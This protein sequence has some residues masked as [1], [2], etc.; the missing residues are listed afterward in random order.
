MNTDSS[1]RGL[2]LPGII[3]QLRPLGLQAAS[4]HPG[5]LTAQKQMSFSA[6][7]FSLR[8]KFKET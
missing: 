5:A 8:K 6:A 3:V 2:L 7:N 1:A 4:T